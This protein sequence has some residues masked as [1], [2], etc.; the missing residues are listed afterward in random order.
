MNA[1]RVIV[2]SRRMD[3]L[4]HTSA[5]V[6]AFQRPVNQACAMG[7]GG[8]CLACDA[9]PGEPCRNPSLKT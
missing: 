9:R 6:I 1:L 3:G 5:R 8:V 7:E 4:Q 2:D